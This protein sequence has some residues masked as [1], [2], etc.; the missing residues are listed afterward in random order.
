MEIG[1]WKVENGLENNQSPFSILH[2]PIKSSLIT[3]LPVALA[4][5]SAPAAHE[6]VLIDLW[7]QNTA[8]FGVYV[9]NENPPTP[10]Q[11]RNRERRPP[12]YTKEGGE[13]LAQNPLYDFVFLNLEGAYDVGAVSAIAEGLRSTTAV[14][15]KTLLVRI[16][17]ISTDG[18]E[19]ARTR[20]KEI[21]DLGADGVILPHVRNVEEA[22]LAIGFFAEAGAD[23]WSPSNPSGEIIAMIMIEDSQALAQVT[24]IADTPGYSILA[25]GIGSLTRALDGDREAAEAG[26]QEVLAHAKRVGVADMITANA[27]SIEQ[28]VREGFLALLMQGPT[29][30]DV[31]MLGRTAAG[32]TD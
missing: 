2:S 28:R 21:L 4:C 31:I 17:P 29:A 3:L 8:A 30:D 22:R 32:R 1:K 14:S 10:E 5:Q 23:V 13:R 6:N 27:E 26:N 18:E 11:W 9:P 24:E 12:V 20:V 7:A 25:C 19:A 15:R 16:P